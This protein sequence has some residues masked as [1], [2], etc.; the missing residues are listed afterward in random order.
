MG[1]VPFLAWGGGDADDNAGETLV[2]KQRGELGERG[3]NDVFTEEL[4]F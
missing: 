4:L 3:L 1:W 2:W